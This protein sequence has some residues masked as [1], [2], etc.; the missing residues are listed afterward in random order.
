MYETGRPLARSKTNK[1]ISKMKNYIF[2]FIIFALLLSSCNTGNGAVGKDTNNAGKDT[3]SIQ[4]TEPANVNNNQAMPQREIEHVQ[5]LI[6]LFEAQNIHDIANKINYPLLRQYPIA[7]INN[8]HEMIQRF[9]AVFDHN[10]MDRIA[11]SSMEQWSAVGWRGLMLDDGIVWLDSETG[12]IIAINYETEKEKM[13][14]NALIKKQKQSLHPSLQAF[15]RP[16]C[17]VTSP[18]NRIRVD[19]MGGDIYRLALWKLNATALAKPDIV[20][21]NGELVYDGSGGNHYYRF[22]AGNT[23]YTLYRNVLRNTDMSEFTLEI[24]KDG[25]LISSH[26]A[27]N[28]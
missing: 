9:D 3:V 20:I 23:S 27:V 15:E 10:I 2:T 21:K 19:A 8:R 17:D 7:P 14:W 13:H 28:E 6:A 16:V 11:H 12:N 1:Y 18:E 24:E 26:D 4:A 5:Q 25:E 22:V